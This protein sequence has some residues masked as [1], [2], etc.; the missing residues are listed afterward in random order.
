MGFDVASGACSAIVEAVVVALAVFLGATIG[1]CCAFDGVTPPTGAGV[2]LSLPPLATPPASNSVLELRGLAA[3]AGPPA[4]TR[5]VF[6][7]DDD[8]DDDLS[9]TPHADAADAAPV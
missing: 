4:L 8:D 5:E 1:G 9:V 6:E 2:A 3:E 7:G